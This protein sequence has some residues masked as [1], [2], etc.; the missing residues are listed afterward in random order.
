LIAASDD[1]GDL[2]V[3]LD[4][5]RALAVE[6][7]ALAPAEQAGLISVVGRT[8]TFRH[9]LVR[10][11]LYQG[12]TLGQRL[13]VHRALAGAL[14]SPADSDRRGGD[15]AAAAAG[16]GE[17]GAAGFGGTAGGARARGGEAAAP[18]RGRRAAAA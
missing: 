17:A 8:V 6:A 2:G 9:P 16:P 13:A 1:S 18:A 7:T 12:A 4:A 10:A 15:P 14:R 11:A 5:A 3:L